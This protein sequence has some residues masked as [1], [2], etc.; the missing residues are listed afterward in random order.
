MLVF[1]ASTPPRNPVLGLQAVFE[2]HAF[3]AV[4]LTL[5]RHLKGQ[6]TFGCMAGNSVPIH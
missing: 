1:C 3:R 5:N 2:K 6:I 4:W